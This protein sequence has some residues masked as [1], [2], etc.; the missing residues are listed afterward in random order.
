MKNV[1]GSLAMLRILVTVNSW[2]LGLAIA[3]SWGPVV[4]PRA[5]HA[6][7]A[8][9][10]APGSAVELDWA[11]K[12]VTGE[13]LERAPS[14]WLKVKFTWNGSE[15]TPTLP[16]AKLRAVAKAPE[17]AGPLR[18]WKDTTG[19]FEIEAGFL[20]KD[21]EN[22]L[23]QKSGGVT[24]KVPLDKLSAEDQ[25]HVAELTR[26]A[27]DK[28]AE[29]MID[30]AN[31]FDTAEVVK[32]ASKPVAKSA[33]PSQEQDRAA[34][35]STVTTVVPQPAADK[36]FVPDEERGFTFQ[37]SNK[38]AVLAGSAPGNDRFF[39]GPRSVLI[40]KQAGQ[41]VL[42]AV[43]SPPGGERTLRVLRC[44]LAT[45][46]PLGAIETQSFGTPV[47][48]SP[49]GKLLACFPDWTARRHG[50]GEMIEIVRIENDSLVPV[51]RWPMGDHANREQKFENLYFVGEDRLL[52]TSAWGSIV[53]WD[54]DKAQAIWQLKLSTHHKPAVSANRKHVAA[55][56]GGQ[57]CVLETATGE[58]VARFVAPTEPHGVLSISSDGKR[59]AAL[60]TRVLHVWDIATGRLSGEVWFPKQLFARSLDWCGGD[61]VLVDRGTL[62]DVA[63][64]IVVWEY[65]LPTGRP[66]AIATMAGGRY[67][68]ASG[69]GNSGYQLA[70]FAVPD[71][72]AKE[73][74]DSLTAAQVLAVKP[75][76]AVSIKINLPGATA[77][78]VKKVQ[79]HLIEEVKGIGLVLTPNAPLVI[80]CSIA[81]QGE[82]K[83]EYSKSA[84]PFGPI[85]PFPRGPFGPFGPRGESE[86]AKV[87]KRLSVISIKENGKELWVASGHYGA[88][89]HV[90]IKEGQTLQQAV[91]EQKGN[92]VQ[93]FQTAKLPRYVARHGEDGT[94]GKSKL[95]P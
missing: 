10:L 81:N 3:L 58:T 78:E 32:P 7:E 52:T 38:A 42:A 74:G 11:G 66:D 30:P 47:D 91:D 9:E 26:P 82:E 84:L 44:D 31:P 90:Q 70:G 54:I 27:G 88:P 69:S 19:R 64:R 59:V 68:L 24:I 62:V 63:K 37:P 49:S 92:P 80:E 65:D 86:E 75:G 17:S 93:F 28:P 35:Y 76:A 67:W 16:P 5:A 29:P 25:A 39:E 36:P 1:G 60:S 53:L 12:T 2:T 14:G 45:M 50:E 48:V 23:L 21:G 43:N 73:L 72:A 87:E 15:M 95:W 6:Q 46:K 4:S 89:F 22:V 77:D 83:A 8:A 55:L 34:D 57:I 56:I 85:G 18:K 94:Y 51:R 13:V 79:N 20:K 33:A 40:A 61:Y 41:A 71:R